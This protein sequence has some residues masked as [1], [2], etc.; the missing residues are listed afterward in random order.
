MLRLFW[1]L[2]DDDADADTHQHTPAHR[3]EMVCGCRNAECHC[4]H[5]RLL[6]GG[7]VFCESDKTRGVL[8]RPLNRCAPRTRALARSLGK[9]HT[10]N[11]N[12]AT[13]HR[14]S[15]FFFGELFV[16]SGDGQ[17]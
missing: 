13:V 10:K 8:S 14:L 16:R 11:G 9:R 7:F 12:E 17:E 1:T 15:V 2:A 6:A 5:K 4:E 3:G